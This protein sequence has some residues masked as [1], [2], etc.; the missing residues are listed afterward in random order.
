MLWLKLPQPYSFTIGFI[1]VHNW[2]ISHLEN[3]SMDLNARSIQVIEYMKWSVIIYGFIVRVRCPIQAW[4]RFFKLN[5]PRN[6]TYT[7]VNGMA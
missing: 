2:F 3:I 4:G 6:M 5:I 7:V 1:F